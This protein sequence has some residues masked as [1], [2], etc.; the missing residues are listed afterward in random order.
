MVAVKPGSGWQCTPGAL[1]KE[2][3]LGFHVNSS[4]S[5]H[6]VACS[7]IYSFTLLELLLSPECHLIHATLSLCPVNS[8]RNVDTL[9][10]GLCQGPGVKG[11]RASRTL[12]GQFEAFQV[13]AGELGNTERREESFSEAGGSG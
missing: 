9:L 2:L 11:S 6:L 13:A 8:V 7:F 5:S 12:S 4:V 10:L 1:I 3:E